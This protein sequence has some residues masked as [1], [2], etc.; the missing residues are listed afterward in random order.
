MEQ[1]QL[2]GRVSGSSI[3]ISKYA[4]S[5]SAIQIAA[6]VIIYLAIGAWVDNKKPIFGHPCIYTMGLGLIVSYF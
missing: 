6:L 5:Q 3:E 1:E 4:Y 2:L